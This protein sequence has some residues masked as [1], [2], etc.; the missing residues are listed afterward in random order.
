MTQPKVRELH[1]GLIRHYLDSLGD[2][3][4]VIHVIGEE[5][6]G[7]LSFAQFWVD[8]VAEWEKE[9]GKHPLIGLSC[10][11]DVQ[12][13]ILADPERAKVIDVIDMKYWW[14]T[15]DGPPYAPK[16]GEQVAP[17]KAI[18]AWKGP[19]NRTDDSLAKQVRD[20]RDKYPDKAIICSY[21]RMDGWSVVAAGG[22][23][24]GLK[25][26]PELLQALAQMKPYEP[27]TPL[28][29]NDWALTE[30]EKQYLVYAM[31]GGAI[32]LDL[33]NASGTFAVRWIDPRSGAMHAAAD[34][35]GGKASDFKSP[36]SGPAVLWLTRK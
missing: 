29:R 5:Y 16:G 2:D 6:S 32:Q 26:D 20:Y 4:N 35:D 8:T 10:P 30:E 9:T 36:G 31:S 34:V 19:K 17:R 28:G 12:D 7:P 21:D 3:H 33:T 14:Y 1:R 23:M 24:A 13:G 18:L 25:A 11:K 15:A 27:S 22:S